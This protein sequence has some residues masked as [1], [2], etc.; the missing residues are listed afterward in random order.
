MFHIL[1]LHEII[2]NINIL[3]YI[4]N[5]I[6][7]IKGDKILSWVPYENPQIIE[8][9]LGGSNCNFFIYTLRN[10]YKFSKIGK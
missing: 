2:V 7:F 1:I 8:D 4:L 5:I 10:L 6:N 9:F 3:I